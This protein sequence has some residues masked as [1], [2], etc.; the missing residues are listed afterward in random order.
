MHRLF[1]LTLGYAQGARNCNKH[2]G[3]L[4]QGCAKG[5]LALKPLQSEGMAAL[6][7]VMVTEALLSAELC[8]HSLDGNRWQD[9]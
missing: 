2:C 7:A 6:F 9:C 5:V 1:L 4:V 3:P 8:S